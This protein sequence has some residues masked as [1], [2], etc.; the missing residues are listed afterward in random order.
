MSNRNRMPVPHVLNARSVTQNGPNNLRP[1]A[2]GHQVRPQ[3]VGAPP[4]LSGP[5]PGM[6]EQKISTQHSEI[7]RLLTENQ[8]L[9]ATHVA[10]RQELAAAQ[11]EVQRLQALIAGIQA[12]KDGQMRALLDKSGKLE[13]D[14]RAAEPL[15]AELHQAQTDC[16]KLHV[17]S[18]ELAQQVRTVSQE[19]Q[20]ARVEAQQVPSMRAEL[21]TLRQELQRARAAFELE[22][23]AN[24]EQL[25]QRQAME[26]NL[27]SMARDLE[28]LRAEHTNADNRAHHNSGVASYNGGYSVQDGTYGTMSQQGYGDGY[29]MHSQ[30]GANPGESD[31]NKSHAEAN[32]YMTVQD[33]NSAYHSANGNLIQQEVSVAQMQQGGTPAQQQQLTQYAQP[34]QN[35]A[36][37]AASYTA[38]PGPQ[39]QQAGLYVQHPGQP[40]QQSSLSQ[41][42]QIS[43][44]R[45][46]AYS[47]QS[48][49]RQQPNL[50][51]SQAHPRTPAQAATSQ[52]QSLPQGPSQP[53]HTPHGTSSTPSVLTHPVFHP[54]LV[55][56]WAML[57]HY[58]SFFLLCLSSFLEA[59]QYLNS[60]LHKS[61]GAAYPLEEGLTATEAAAAARVGHVPSLKLNY[62]EVLS[63]CSDQSFWTA[64]DKHPQTVPDD[65]IA[66]AAVTVTRD[67]CYSGGG[68]REA[69]LLRYKEKRR[70][71]LFSKKIRYEVRKL[72]AEQRPR[73]KGRFV[74]KTQWSTPE[75]GF[76]SY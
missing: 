54:V 42:N 62:K 44:S 58:K 74:K 50:Q 65:P 5:P 16:Q 22:K 6:L 27:V 46:G 66:D 26:K 48:P 33:G 64:N 18:Q 37:H 39:M 76:G 20:R 53:S 36:Q 55:A 21:D 56:S 57:G 41:P 59:V 75:D 7:Q 72:N 29:S 49:Q 25:E 60:T 9:A 15:K 70:A 10:L 17:H 35:A 51:Q 63:A 31:I 52:P 19:L 67:D 61:I 40:M 8:R 73:M 68:R 11:Q 43:S 30:Q 32:K 2:Y 23:K 4:V 24:S 71:R 38:H 45:P 47:S 12:E 69:S 13:A 14:L 3:L 28:K 1:L 34:V